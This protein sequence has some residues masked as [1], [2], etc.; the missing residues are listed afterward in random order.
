MTQVTT[1]GVWQQATHGV[2]G[3]P[4]CQATQGV[5]CVQPG[6]FK[7]P[8]AGRKRKYYADDIDLEEMRRRARIL[9]D[10]RDMQDLLE[11]VRLLNEVN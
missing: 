1:L 10:R 11:M 7:P 9:R 5:F 6:P 2:F 4:W 3:G 8:G